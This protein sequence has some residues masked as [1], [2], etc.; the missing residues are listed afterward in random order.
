ML[1]DVQT[2][3]FFFFGYAQT[4]GVLDDKE[5]NGHGDSDPS[6]DANHAEQ[7]YEEEVCAVTIE[8]TLIF[9]EQAGQQGAQSTVYA[10]YA[11]SANRIVNLENFFYKFNA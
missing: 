8:Q 10:V 11:D 5:Y 7:L 4:D 9:C 2:A 6:D 3:D 1:H